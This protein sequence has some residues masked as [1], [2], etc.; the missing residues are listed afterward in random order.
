ME[1]SCSSNKFDD[2]ELKKKLP[3]RLELSHGA[4]MTASIETAL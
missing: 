2:R 4:E 1:S 3:R